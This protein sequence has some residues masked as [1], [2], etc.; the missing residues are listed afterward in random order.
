MNL[1]LITEYKSYPAKSMATPKGRDITPASSSLSPNWIARFDT[2]AATLSTFICSLYVNQWFWLSTLKFHL[3]KH[4][5]FCRENTIWLSTKKFHAVQIILNL[6]KSKMWKFPNRQKPRGVTRMP[7]WMAR[8]R[9]S[10][11]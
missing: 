2:A 9:D 7:H 11:F 5:N 3:I 8:H 4:D 6:I 1:Y 10:L